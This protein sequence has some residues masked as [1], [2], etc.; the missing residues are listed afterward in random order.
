MDPIYEISAA[1]H[2]PPSL[3]AM[4]PE[5]RRPEHLASWLSLLLEKNGG[6]DLSHAAGD[7]YIG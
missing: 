7:Y 6:F 4:T 2:M 3:K 1:P 5:M